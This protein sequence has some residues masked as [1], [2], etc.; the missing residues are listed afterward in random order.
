MTD[1]AQDYTY[2]VTSVDSSGIAAITMTSY[3]SLQYF[4]GMRVHASTT[5]SDVVTFVKSRVDDAL[6]KWASAR[7]P[8]TITV[9]SETSLR[10]RTRIFNE[11][12]E[13]N[14]LTHKIVSSET[15]DSYNITTDY[16]SVPLNDSEK[17]EV[18]SGVFSTRASLW[19]KLDGEGRLDSVLSGLDV[20]IGAHATWD[21]S[22]GGSFDWSTDKISSRNVKNVE[23]V[24]TGRYKVY[25]TNELSD[26]SYSTVCTAGSTDY[27]GSGSSPRNLSVMNR[28]TDYVEVICERS[29]DAV[30]EDNFYNS[31]IVVNA[32]DNQFDSH[33]ININHQERFYFDDAVTQRIQTILGL[34]DSDMAEYL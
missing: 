1:S 5:D 23:R 15:V 10:Y 24:E 33:G 13:F 26:S 14:Y 6:S 34:V 20:P 31:V 21:A 22:A 30:N 27:S 19:N 29:D 17:A 32:Q 9:G 3:D 28:Q 8:T 18:Y 4:T 7:A 11:L 16:N 25:F 12:P 2:E